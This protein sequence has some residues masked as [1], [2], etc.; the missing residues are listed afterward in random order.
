[1][2]VIPIFVVF[3]VIW[4]IRS[5]GASGLLV[6]GGVLGVCAAISTAVRIDSRLWSIP[7]RVRHGLIGLWLIITAGLS[8]SLVFSGVRHLSGGRTGAELAY[9][10]AHRSAVAAGLFIIWL[11]G[12]SAARRAGVFLI[13]LWTLAVFEAVRLMALGLHPIVFSY[14][15]WSATLAAAVLR[16]PGIKNRGFRVKM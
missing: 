16:I 9:I 2:R 8:V 5:L 14:I 13:I 15:I 1:M 12:C 4:T 6:S 7:R 11:I 3:G 10:E